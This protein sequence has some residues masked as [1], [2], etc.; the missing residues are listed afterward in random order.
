MNSRKSK[1]LILF[2]L[3]L[4]GFLI[5]LLVIFYRVNIERKLPK[6]ETSYFN[7]ALR[8]SII[9]KDG[10]NVATSQK[11][12]K[13]TID[14]RNI[15]PNKK[16]MLIK[17]YSI[18]S[19]D[20]EKSIRQKINSVKGSLILSYKVDA[21]GAAYL[22]EL[23]RKLYKNKIFIPYEDPKTG[24]VTTRGMDITE[25]G[26]N[27][28]YPTADKLT[29]LI[30]YIKK[31]EKDG[32][33]KR[34]GV[35]GV[36]KS[37]EYYI[38]PIQ[39]AKLIGP[40][41][42]GNNIILTNDSNLA[43]R[44]DGYDA[45][46]SIS[47]KFQSKLEQIIDEKR[48]FLD[49][50]E[51]IVG[52]MNSKTGELLALAT[53][54]RYDPS[55]IQKKD[56]SSLNSTATE[57][58]YE[59]GSVFKPFI[60]SI[61]LSENKVNPLELINTYNGHYQLGKRII[62]DTHPETY[63]SAEDIIVYSSNIGMIQL[64]QRLEGRELY[65]GLSSYGFAQKT[66]IDMPYEQVGN[67]PPVAKLNSQVYKAT[68][69]YG[70]GLQATFMQLLKA[71]NI[72]NNKGVMVTPR[73]VSSLYKNGKFFNVNKSEPI[74]VIGQDVAKRMKR[75][76]VKTVTDGTGL[77]AKTLGLEVGGKTGTA[78]IATT[79]GY[80]NLYNGSFFG[81]VND[82]EGNSYTIGVLA[83]EPKRPYYYFGAQSALPTFKAA[84]DLLVEDGY[85]KIDEKVVQAD[86][87]RDRKSKEK[88]IVND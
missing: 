38:S 22:Q 32:I 2:S 6:I 83:R 8:G 87:E 12:Y 73:V 57:Y 75:I 72:F 79:G 68:I 27:R 42:I 11:I 74:Q 56:Y 30:G 37:Y 26:E 20:D 70:Y 4:F 18:Y 49:A 10:F 14:T 88:K 84:I 63:M 51:L 46:L 69:S 60:F 54:S 58:A 43:S 16:D 65:A 67:M 76:L 5:F 13:V 36:E 59:V 55:N 24:I 61:L 47:L 44:V 82:S 34:T 81:F 39:D 25:S 48:A 50:K 53:T 33:T 80:L 52:V 41:D 62:R 3:V 7:T 66:G 21:K 45:I 77:K 17:L 15:D 23:S 35:K 71:Y 1:I 9:T 78:H 28:Q 40:K 85:L 29:P 31:I 19:G 86:L 64:A